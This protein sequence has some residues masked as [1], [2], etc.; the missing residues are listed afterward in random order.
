MSKVIATQNG[1]RCDKAEMISRI[2]SKLDEIR[3]FPT[4]P[5]VAQEA[6]RIIA[7][8]NSSMH[9]LVHVIDGDMALTSRI[10]RIAN[11]AY[12]GVPR[13]IDN[14][15]MA[16]VVL[17]MKEINNLVTTISVMRLFPSDSEFAAFD[18][19]RFWK[20][21]AVCAELTVGLYQGLRMHLPSSVY[22]A[23][24]LHDVGK[25]VLA[26]YFFDQFLKCLEVAVN[27]KVTFAEAEIR[28]F[29][30][31]HGHIGSWLIKRWS[32]PDEICDAVAKH[33]VR[34]AN[35]PRFDLA[36]VIDWADRLYYLMEGEFANQVTALLEK[37]PEWNIWKASAGYPT[38]KVVEQLYARMHRS[39]TLLNLLK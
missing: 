30:I 25:L 11:S 35:S 18:I 29:G 36:A 22:I 10:L 26:Q 16:L 2:R 32:I 17:G 12:Y 13:K 39:M 7:D 34:P 20:H 3:D 19:P 38:P 9:D 27:E 37:D 23:G 4:L 24:L 1:S 15:K 8:P 33:H 5:N 31:D 21:S 6:R 14:L 28:Q